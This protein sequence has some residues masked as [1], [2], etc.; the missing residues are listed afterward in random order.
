MNIYTIP[1][2][3]EQAIERFYWCFDPD[4]G[5]L[6]VE[7]SEMIS[8]QDALEE[9]QNQSD[10]ILQWY[11]QDRANRKAR[12]EMIMLEIN[13][14]SEQLDREHKSIDRIDMLISRAFERVYDGKPVNIWT[15]TLSYRNS[16]AVLIEDESKIPTEF[17]KIPEP[18][19]P[20]PDKKSIKEAIKEGKEV[21]GASIETRKNI[22]I[23]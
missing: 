15:F 10:E 9:L 22:T 14:L 8:A 1:Q 19:S 12:S 21:P 6:I 17:M 2:E 23:K 16:E 4:T 13:R 18:P 3:V 7:E 11:L 5:E 20:K